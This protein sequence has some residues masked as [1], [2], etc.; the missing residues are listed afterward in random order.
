MHGVGD[1]T[2]VKDAKGVTPILQA[3]PPDNTRGTP[4]AK[5]FPGR[6]ET[7]AWAYERAD[8]GRGFGFTGGHNH[9]NLGDENFPRVGTNALLWTA[10]E[11][12]PS[13]RANVEVDPTEPDAQLDPQGKPFPQV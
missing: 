6:L 11:G 7:M 3:I 13:R 1:V 9:R 10:E 8:G 4:D 12:V 2:D 5:R